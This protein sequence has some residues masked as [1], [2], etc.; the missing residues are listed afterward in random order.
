MS[1]DAAYYESDEKG[2]FYKTEIC[3][4]YLVFIFL[5]LLPLPVTYQSIKMD[6]WLTPRRP[7]PDASFSHRNLLEA[8]ILD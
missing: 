4:I 1:N 6:I 8:V 5:W 3:D 7:R 2:Q